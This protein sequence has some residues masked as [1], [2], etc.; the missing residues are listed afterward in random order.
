[1]KR[2]FPFFIVSLIVTFRSA[3]SDY[4][5]DLTHSNHARYLCGRNLNAISAAAMLYATNHSG[6]L[7]SR[8][9]DMKTELGNPNY[10]VCPESDIHFKD[11]WSD[12]DESKAA[13]RVYNPNVVKGI[14]ERYIY[15][16]IHKNQEILA[17]GQVMARAVP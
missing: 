4:D 15:C 12:F 6:H 11:D 16:R 2:I 1:M 7:P 5:N 14:S 9:I 8:L 13:Y 17:D 10:L 3:A